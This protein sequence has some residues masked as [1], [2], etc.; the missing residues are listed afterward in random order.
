MRVKSSNPPLLGASKAKMLIN[1][2][3]GQGSVIKHESTSE[4]YAIGFMACEDG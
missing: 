3:N 2:A 4:Q 1:A